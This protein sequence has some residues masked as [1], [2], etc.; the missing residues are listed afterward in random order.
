VSD[1]REDKNCPAL[2]E[3]RKSSTSYLKGLLDFVNSSI[4][5]ATETLAAIEQ[6]LRM[7]L[8]L[9]AEDY[10]ISLDKVPLPEKE[11]QEPNLEEPVNPEAL[12]RF[13]DAYEEL[14]RAHHLCLGHEDTNGGFL[15][16]PNGEGMMEWTRGTAESLLWDPER[17]HY[18]RNF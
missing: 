14:C 12:R 10:R 2:E 6:N 5:E 11:E 17:P 1:C 15:V 16:V 4:G 13:L 9:A 7:V 18:G 8:G 3:T